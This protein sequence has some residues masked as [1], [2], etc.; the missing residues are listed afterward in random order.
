MVYSNSHNYSTELGVQKYGKIRTSTFVLLRIAVP[1]GF[2]SCSIIN[3]W[4]FYNKFGL[5]NFYV[6]EYCHTYPKEYGL[7]WASNSHWNHRKHADCVSL[8]GYLHDLHVF[9]SFII[10]LC[11]VLGPRK[12]VHI[13]H[14]IIERNYCKLNYRTRKY[15]TRNYR[16]E[17]VK[18]RNMGKTQLWNT[19]R[20]QQEL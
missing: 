16:T 2:G 8:G 15:R 4:L 6:R 9:T 14:R 7:I 5:L 10:I 12:N 1:C 18:V 13:E 11:I 3:F 19:T 20:S 17:L